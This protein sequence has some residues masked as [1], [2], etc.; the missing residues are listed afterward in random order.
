MDNSGSTRLTSGLRMVVML[1]V[2]PA[3]APSWCCCHAGTAECDCCGT[4]SPPVSRPLCNCPDGC[5]CG[6][7]APRSQAVA[8][9]GR[10]QL[11]SDAAKASP[12][13]RHLRDS[14]A[15]SCHTSLSAPPIAAYG[16]ERCIALCRLNR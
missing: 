11:R 15:D 14:L 8:A 16:A 1:L 3:L 12:V 5:S 13:I 6:R 2:L 9:K 4:S 7:S 10:I